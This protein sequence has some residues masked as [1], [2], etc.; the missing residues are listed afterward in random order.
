M[1]FE[2]ISKTNAFK[3]NKGLVEQEK[4]EMQK[5]FHDKRSDLKRIEASRH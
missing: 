5:K 2:P 4:S 1:L 3:A